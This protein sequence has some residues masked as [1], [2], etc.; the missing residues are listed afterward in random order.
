MNINKILLVVLL[1]LS[2]NGCLGCQVG[3]WEIEQCSDF[4]ASTQSKPS[5]IDSKFAGITNC[6]CLNS[7]T[8]QLNYK[9]STQN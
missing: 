2:L 8:R 4:C 1:I 3:G 6:T 7:T 5:I 9:A